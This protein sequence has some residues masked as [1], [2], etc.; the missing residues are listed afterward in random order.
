MGQ[1]Y[2]VGERLI[3]IMYTYIIINRHPGPSNKTKQ[4]RGGGSNNSKTYDN[5]AIE[6]YISRGLG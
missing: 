1:Q 2:N 5:R 4:T 3:V 6:P